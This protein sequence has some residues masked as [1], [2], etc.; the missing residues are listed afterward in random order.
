MIGLLEGR[1][2]SRNDHGLIVEVGGIGFEVAVPLR[3]MESLPAAGGSVRLYT[4]LHWKEDGPALFGFANEQ[5]RAFFRLLLTVAGVGPRVALNCLGTADVQRLAL[6]MAT[7]DE[8]FLT[9]LPGIGRKTAQRLIVELKDRINSA[10]ICPSAPGMIAVS[11]PDEEA[12]QALL[13]LGYSA[14]E[15]AAAIDQARIHLGQAEEQPATEAIV[16]QALRNLS[17]TR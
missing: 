12:V 15:A 13:A 4:H 3:V 9:S 7:G 6:A 2:V 11:G 14:Q 8:R 16:R 5:E 17:K 1:V 10:E